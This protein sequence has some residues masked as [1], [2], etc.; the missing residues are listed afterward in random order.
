MA[1][2]ISVIIPV[3]KAE[4]FIKKC[5]RS[6]CNQSYANYELIFIDDA[7]PDESVRII[8]EEL[9]KYPEFE[10]K[11]KI[12]QNSENLGVGP[13]RNLG[14]EI[15][16]GEWCVFVDSDDWV[17]TS[18]LEN[19]I[20]RDFMDGDVIIGG[21]VYEKEDSEEGVKRIFKDSE[22]KICH[23]KAQELTCAIRY[24]L[25]CGRLY[26]MKLIRR[27]LLRF[28]KIALHE[29]TLFFMRYLTVAS[30]I[31]FRGCCD[32]HYIQYNTH[33]LSKKNRSPN[34]YK[35]ISKLLLCA[36]DSLLHKLSHINSYDIRGVVQTYGLSQLLLAVQSQ[37]LFYPSSKHERFALLAA[38][39][40]R[41]N[42]FLKSRRTASPLK[43]ASIS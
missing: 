27:K 38:V 28:E 1:P 29:D 16:A 4:P 10:R 30:R 24:S 14:L 3:Y 23:I 19:L 22:N 35:E 6:L 2:L 21:F 20:G 41:R 5:V 12:I 9:S 34:E 15:A 33:S 42:L 8:K 31:V 18:F 37:Y 25:A 39:K 43:K 26:D 11:V 7:S 17:S 32:Y 36:W 13:S 40:S